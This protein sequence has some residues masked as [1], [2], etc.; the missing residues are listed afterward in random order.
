MSHTYGHSIDAL[1]GQN[2]LRIRKAKGF[3]QPVLGAA[4]G[5]SFPQIQKYETGVNRI[6]A[7]TLYRLA[8]V[9]NIGIEDLF[10][11]VDIAFGHGKGV[12]ADGHVR[13]ITELDRIDD[14]NVR[15]AMRSLVRCLSARPGPDF[16]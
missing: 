8:K 15:N 3:S 12:Q 11:G 1:V 5:I 13:Q 4:V 6:S 10:V 16:V 2:L 7:S 14:S 9:L